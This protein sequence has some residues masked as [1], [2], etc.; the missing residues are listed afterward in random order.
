MCTYLGM[1][2]YLGI[3]VW[4]K[5]LQTGKSLYQTF[6]HFM[7]LLYISIPCYTIKYKL[8]VQ[9]NGACAYINGYCIVLQ[10]E[11]NIS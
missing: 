10:L 8:V 9:H 1:F 4:I 3:V 7:S 2:T 6:C 11:R 5:V